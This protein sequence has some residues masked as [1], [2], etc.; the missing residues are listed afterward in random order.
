MKYW[1]YVGLDACFACF[2]LNYQGYLFL[3]VLNLVLR[4]LFLALSLFSF[5]LDCDFVGLH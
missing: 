3:P 1:C 4:M 2:E 5:A